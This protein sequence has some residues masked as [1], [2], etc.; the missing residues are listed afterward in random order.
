MACFLFAA[1]VTGAENRGRQ[2]SYKR[3]EKDGI[4]LKKEWIATYDMRTRHAH[5]LLDGQLADQDKLFKSEL[6]D[7][8]FP[9]DPNAHPSNVYNCRCTTAAK[10]MGF[11]KK[12]S[13]EGLTSKSKYAKIDLQFFASKEKQFGKKVGK[14]AYDFGLDPSIAS[15][16][17][18]FNKI[19]NTIV[20]D[21]EEVSVGEWRSQE[22]EVY[23][24]IRG[25]DVVVTNQ[26]KEFITILKGGIT[27][28]RV[29]RARNG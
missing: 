16:R 13:G 2:D 7:I 18:K 27:N 14:H 21:H 29:K 25:E 10:I 26:S 4:I 1:A 9:G 22:N 23:F 19:I 5:A 28:A 8:M 12:N 3:A 11:R 24:F 20:D 15:D 6:G 17:E